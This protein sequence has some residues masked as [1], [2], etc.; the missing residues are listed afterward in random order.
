MPAVKTSRSKRYSWGKVPW[1]Y[2]GIDPNK[3][4]KLFEKIRQDHDG[5]LFDN[6]IVKEARARSSPIHARFVWDDKEAAR[7]HRLKTAREMK[8]HLREVI[9]VVE[10]QPPEERRVY[11]HVRHEGESFHTTI[12]DASNPGEYVDY[13]EH[14]A[15]LYLEGVRGR[16]EE[17]STRF[18]FIKSVIAAVDRALKRLKAKEK[19]GG[20]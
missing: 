18:L 5:Q 19:K 20:K 1:L 10:G 4:A 11:V 17:L 15:Q 7:L 12:D 8:E 14:E 13:V 2:R 3:T 9:V 16:L 6:D